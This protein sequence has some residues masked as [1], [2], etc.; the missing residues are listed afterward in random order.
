MLNQPL[1]YL[2]LYFKTYRT[3]Y[4]RLV[5]EVREQGAWEAWLEFFL[6]GVATTAGEASRPEIES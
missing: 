4:Y 1:L 2:S 3:D 6:Q 5:Q